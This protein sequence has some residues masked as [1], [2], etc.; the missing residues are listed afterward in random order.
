MIKAIFDWSIQ[1]L[2]EKMKN[3]N[4]QLVNALAFRIRPM[5]G[6]KFEDICV[7]KFYT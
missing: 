1:D 2:I 3:S 7:A 5:D 6:E 4:I